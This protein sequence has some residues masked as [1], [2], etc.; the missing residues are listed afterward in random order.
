MKLIFTLLSLCLFQLT[1]AAQQTDKMDLS[2]IWRFQLDPMGFGKIPG[3]ELYQTKLTETI[4]LPGS[5]DQAGKEF[6]IK[7]LMWIGYHENMNI[8]DRRGISGKFSSRK[9]GLV[10]KLS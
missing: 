10:R 4:M 9:I 3:S 8:V 2:G 5:T 1:F 6:R 7:S